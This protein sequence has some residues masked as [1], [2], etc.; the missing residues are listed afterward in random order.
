[1]NEAQ[2]VHYERVPMK[3]TAPHGSFRVP[4]DVVAALGHGDPEMGIIVL[5]D[6]FAS[7]PYL[8]NGTPRILTPEIVR[9]IGHGSL[10][11][12]RRVLEKFVALIRRRAK[13]HTH[14][15]AA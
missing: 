10:S 15:A 5:Y 4:D 1:M 3:G 9:D 2:K 7:E 13:V 11:A 14:A 12:G 6:M 8:S